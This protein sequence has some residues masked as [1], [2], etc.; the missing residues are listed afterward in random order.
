MILLDPSARVVI[1]HRGNRAHAPENT[2]ESFRQAIARGADAIELDV[3]VSRDGTL[4]VIH[5]PTLDRTTNGSG[6]VERLTLAQLRL[7]DAGAK[8][9]SDGGKTFSYRGRGITIPTFDEV[10]EVLP[11]EL[12]LII[13]LKTP[14]ATAPISDAVR[15]H[16]I[17]NRIIVASFDA[18]AVHPLRGQGFALGAAAG[19]V[20]SLMIPSLIGRRIGPQQF[21]ALCI[22]P[23]WNGIPVP[24]LSMA[25]SLERSGTVIHVWTVNEPARAQALWRGGVQGIISDDPALMLAARVGV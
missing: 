24:I 13:E 9:T 4:V 16:G 25:R 20:A 12:P 19:E 11:R 23:N 10:I 7:L 17:A 14:A 21:Q 3:H 18:T 1:G 2:L 6:A 22:P 8:F 5:D 15:R